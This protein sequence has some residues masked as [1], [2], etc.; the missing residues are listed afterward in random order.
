MRLVINADDFGL[1]PGVTYGILDAMRR[2]AVT[3]TT[4]MVNTAAACLA[5]ELVREDPGLQVGLHLNVSLGRPLSD[6]PSLLRDG[7]FVKPAVLGSDAVYHSEDLNRE[8]EAQFQRFLELT[9]RLPTHLD[10]HLYAHQKLQKVGQA[11]RALADRHRLPVRDCQT[12]W[13]R[14][15]NFIGSFKVLPGEGRPELR[16]K[17]AA[18]LRTL[19][20]EGEA[21]LMA[22]PAFVDGLLLE[23]S[24][25]QLQRAWEHS[26][27]TDPELPGLFEK[28]KIRLVGFRGC[29]GK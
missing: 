26:V 9:G 3:S 10:S 24:S 21:E 19:E 7:C 25:Y 29:T 2:G 23:S 11:V 6:C 5:A 22:H 27:L 28:H 4:M 13:G 18:L 14:A 15:P 12:A 20:G 17:L 1:T 16:A 8:A